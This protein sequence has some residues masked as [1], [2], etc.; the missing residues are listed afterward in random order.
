MAFSFLVGYYS[1]K[2]LAKMADVAD[3]IF[4]SGKKE[5]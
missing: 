5:K 1:D 3:T 4:G 2:A